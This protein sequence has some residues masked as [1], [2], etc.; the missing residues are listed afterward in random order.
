M[1]AI[2]DTNNE[3]VAALDPYDGIG[4]MDSIFHKLVFL[5]SLKDLI[6]L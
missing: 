6:G 4:I 3:L 2:T 5:L 1:K